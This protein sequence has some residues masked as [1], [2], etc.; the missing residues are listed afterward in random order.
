MAEEIGNE[1]AEQPAKE[2]GKKGLGKKKLIIIAAVLAFLIGGGGFVGYTMFLGGKDKGS[3]A[4]QKTDK[5]KTKPVMM[6]LDPFI[7]NLAEHGRFLKLTI[8]FEL[9]D[10]TS[11]PL[12]TERVPQLRDAIITLVSSKSADSLAS[13][14]GKFLLK[15][16]I[17][18]RANQAIGKDVF[19]N[20]YFTE[21][22][23]Q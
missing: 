16:E 15:D 20:L 4:Q 8:Q 6:P 17:L 3:E 14:E 18:L 5:S 10:A 12:V 2:K 21:F 13:P 9:A 22:V 1:G 19:K 11:Q 23:M 7:L